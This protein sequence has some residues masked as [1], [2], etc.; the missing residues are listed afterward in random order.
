[1]S[2]ISGGSDLQAAR[3]AVAAA[4][5]DGELAEIFGNPVDTTVLTDYLDVVKEPMDFGTILAKIDRSLSGDGDTYL[6]AS[7][8]FSDVD[9]VWR[10]CYNYNDRPE[11]KAIVDIANRCKGLFEREWKRQGLHIPASAASKGRDS[12]FDE[13]GT[14]TS[15]KM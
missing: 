3:N 5:N 6:E 7:E 14:L 4:L 15:L 8:V 2:A 13:A 11:D 10:A 1:M 12:A 9:K